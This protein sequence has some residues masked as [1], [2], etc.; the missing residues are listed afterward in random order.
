VWELGE[1]VARTLVSEDRA[2]ARARLAANP[3][4]ETL[5]GEYDRTESESEFRAAIF[6]P[7]LI[8]VFVL[9]LQEHAAWLV[10]LVP[11]LYLLVQARI[12]RDR[13]DEKL[14][15]AITSSPTLKSPLLE[16]LE[17]VV[18]AAEAKHKTP[19]SKED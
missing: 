16:T 14:I 4:L 6:L 11:L 1:D 7:L 12:L 3:A 15:A 18:R 19:S 13:A 5:Y 8:L 2:R 17:D 10:L 9:A